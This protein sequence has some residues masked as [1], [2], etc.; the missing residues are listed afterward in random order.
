M[1]TFL[2]DKVQK[3]QIK[4]QKM[5]SIKVLIT[6]TFLF[7]SFLNNK[8]FKISNELLFVKFKDNVV[9]KLVLR[10]FN[11]TCLSNFSLA[12]EKTFN[13]QT[14]KTTSHHFSLF[15]IYSRSYTPRQT[16]WWAAKL[17]SNFQSFIKPAVFSSSSPLSKVC[18]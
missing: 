3:T 5:S 17:A 8:S 7:W 12:D 11:K 2:S 4:A 13:Q 9:Q 15:L 1:K 16:N 10:I 18:N 6:L 14:S